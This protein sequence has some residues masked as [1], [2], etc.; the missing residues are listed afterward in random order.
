MH[1]L[2]VLAAATFAAMPAIA[3]TWD[4]PT[5]Y[6]DGVFHTANVIAFADDVRAATDGALD[7]TVHSAGSLF[8]HDEIKNAVRARQVQA[9]EF[10]MSRLSNEDA[11]YGIDSQPFVATSYDDARVLWEAQKPIVTEMLAE[12]GLVPLFAVPWPPQGLYTETE[13]TDV[14]QLN[15]L[16]F[17]AYNAQLEEFAALA[18]AAPVQVEASDIPQAFATGQVEAMMT[19]SSTGVN[20][21]A[22]DFLTHYSPIDAWLPKNVVVVNAR[23][24][25]ALDADVR[26]A[27]MDAAAEAE[28]RGWEASMAEAEAQT[29]ALADNGIVVYPPSDELRAGLEGIGEQMLATWDKTASDRGQGHPRGVPLRV[30]P[31]PGPAADGRAF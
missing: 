28:T 10:L 2:A 7:I 11:A 25:D 5:P 27:V 26:Q 6:G 9:G 31:P 24:L 1:S 19:S 13:I 8:P 30:T 21:T 29:Q 3:E 16:R 23:V 4:M 17:R 22:W 15:G 18:G 12:Q 14:A 20:S